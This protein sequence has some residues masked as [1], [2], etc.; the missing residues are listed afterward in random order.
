MRSGFRSPA[1]TVGAAVL[2][3]ALLASACSHPQRTGVIEPRSS[4]DGRPNIL[5][6]EVDSLDPS[7]LGAYGSR[8]GLTPAIDSLAR[9][10]VVFTRA[11]AASPSE[12]AETVALLTGDH[13]HT[14]GM[15]QEWTGAPEW[16]LASPPEVKA[17]PELLRAAGYDTF[18]VGARP[19][20][21]GS[22]ASLW[23]DNTDAP[24]A[25]WASL[26]IRR[27]F[28]GVVDLSARP[29]RAEQT[30]RGFWGRLAFWR[31]DESKQDVAG[32]DP[33]SVTVPAYLPDTPA[34]RHAL[35]SEAGG[36]RRVDAQVGAIVDRLRKAGALDDSVV[37]FTAK[38]GPAR[39]GAERNVYDEGAHVPL[40]VRF[41]GAKGHGT[42]RRD[43]VSGVDIAP[44]ILTLAG[45]K[46]FA[47]MQGRDRI[48]TSADP[49]K[50]VFT[51]QNR[52]DAAYERVFAV[53]DGRWLFLMNLAP[54]TPRS[55]LMRPGPLA[56][57]VTA[58]RR[59]GNLGAEQARLFSDERPDAELYDLSTDPYALHDLAQDPA[60][61]G[62]MSR[63]SQA[64]NAFAASAP[65]YS[66]WSA[67]D[68]EDLFRPG[69]AA[70]IAV[71]PTGGLQ[72]GR[73]VLVSATPG[74]AILWRLQ[75]KAPWRLYTGPLAVSG[76]AQVTA[77]TVRYG[78]R[79]S[80]AVKIDLKK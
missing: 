23:V 14:I 27:P 12:D 68:L 3:A 8:T 66:T 48:T 28:L 42:V 63:L 5:V 22:P 78:F 24:G 50:F 33:A 74:A 72:G 6:I 71:E 69:G 56:D 73:L 38:T 41:P 30:K 49:E 79:D 46:P 44:S 39:P 29:Q 60:H 53:R 31:K 21:F 15:V 34:V 57:A 75:D 20:P 65:D 43:L 36:V 40:I 54:F 17:Y 4:A 76:A 32:V 80:P 62:D 9:D 47:W 26:D 18:H 1:R 70:P 64:L 7:A 58:A 67:Q 55:A 52:V 37:I 10:G 11:Y 59:A 45:L 25:R 2:A 13:P 35:A 61:A 77:K 51:V 19:D 16:T